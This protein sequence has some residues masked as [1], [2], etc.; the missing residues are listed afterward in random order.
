MLHSVQLSRYKQSTLFRSDG[1]D[2]NRSRLEIEFRNWRLSPLTP[3]A[4]PVIGLDVIEGE[5]L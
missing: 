1:F 2:L 4:F 5:E 3:T